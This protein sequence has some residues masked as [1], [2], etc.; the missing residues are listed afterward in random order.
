L[1]W[2]ESRNKKEKKEKKKGKQNKRI[3]EKEIIFF[4]KNRI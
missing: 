2:F 1:F 4:E 3:K